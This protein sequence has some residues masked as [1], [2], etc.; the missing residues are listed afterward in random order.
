MAAVG[1]EDPGMNID[2]LL[3]SNSASTPLISMEDEQRKD[4]DVMEVIKFLEDGVLPGDRDRARKLALQENLLCT[5]HPSRDKHTF[6]NQLAE[7]KRLGTALR[8]LQA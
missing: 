5:F 8:M 4:P 1:S 6:P 2:S 3:Q 7:T